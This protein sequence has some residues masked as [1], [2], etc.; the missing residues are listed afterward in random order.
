[1]VSTLNLAI[2]GLASSPLNQ[3]SNL[4]RKYYD[5]FALPKLKGCC[6]LLE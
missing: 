5:I 6:H 2:K 1:M 4:M 3:G